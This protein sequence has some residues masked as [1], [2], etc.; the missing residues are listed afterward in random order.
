MNG[1][2]SVAR[3]AATTRPQPSRSA[4]EFVDGDL[5]ELD[6]DT[7][8]ALRGNIAK[9]DGDAVVPWGAS[10]EVQGA[11]RRRHWERREGQK[12]LRNVIAWWAGLESAQ[13]RGESESYRRF[14]HRFGID[15]ANAQTLGT[16]EAAE[17]AAR[18]SAELGK[19][20]IDGTV[21]AAAYFANQGAQ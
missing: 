9:I 6:P 3:I 14:Y 16:R 19:Y 21:D 17:L 4:P 1:S 7:L 5:T 10:A 18:V 12:A 11:V 15:V 13:G 2:L 8:A 20:G